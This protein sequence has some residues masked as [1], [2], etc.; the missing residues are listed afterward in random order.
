MLRRLM[1]G[2]RILTPS[3]LVRVQAKQPTKKPPFMGG[4][5]VALGRPTRT[6]GSESKVV[7]RNFKKREAYEDERAH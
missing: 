5:F 1:V 6:K 3:I 4:F 7:E 2:Q